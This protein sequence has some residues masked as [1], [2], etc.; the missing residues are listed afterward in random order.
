MEYH[1][2]ISLHTVVLKYGQKQKFKSTNIVDEFMKSRCRIGVE[3]TINNI[4]LYLHFAL[5]I[6]PCTRTLESRLTT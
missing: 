6:I 5:V 3:S 1:S 2:E 4:I